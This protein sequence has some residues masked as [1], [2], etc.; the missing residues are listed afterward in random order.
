MVVVVVVPGRRTAALHPPHL[1]GRRAAASSSLLLPPAAAEPPPRP[2]LVVGGGGPRAVVLVVVWVVDERVGQE[3]PHSVPQSHGRRWRKTP[4]V[5][6]KVVEVSSSSTPG[7]D[8]PSR[9]SPTTTP[10]A[11]VRRR[12][13]LLVRVLVCGV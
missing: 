13:V 4:G 1:H 12:V 10:Q 5:G 3:P 9:G 11:G 6:G 7:G 2:P 8:S